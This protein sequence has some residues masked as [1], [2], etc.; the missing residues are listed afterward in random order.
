MLSTNRIHRITALSLALLMFFSSL[1]FSMDM[2]YCQGTLKSVALFVKAK[3]CHELAASMP[4]CKHHQLQTNACA[5]DKKDCC[6]NET[7]FFHLDQDQELPATDLMSNTSLLHF[8]SALVAVFFTNELDR[9]HT[10]S[11]ARDYKP[12]LIAQD[13]PVLL[14]SFLL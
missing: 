5:M 10:A 8:A 6:E 1:A 4:N 3:N 7:V 2:H 12:P 9:E 14:Q 13:I 11:P